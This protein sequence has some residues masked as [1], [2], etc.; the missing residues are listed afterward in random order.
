MVL[1]FIRKHFYLLVGVILRQRIEPGQLCID[2]QLNDP[3]SVDVVVVVVE[4]EVVVV[5]V[6]VIVVVGQ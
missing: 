2:S 4:V 6:V 3:I 5:V 1:K